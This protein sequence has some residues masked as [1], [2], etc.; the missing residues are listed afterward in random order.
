MP[1]VGRG[2]RVCASA[3]SAGA[4]AVAGGGWFATKYMAAGVALTR[5]GSGVPAG[6]E[7]AVSEPVL[8]PGSV[9][10]ILQL[11]DVDSTVVAIP[12]WV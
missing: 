11:S 10:T 8:R 12:A 4:L 7:S 5:S 3:S 1:P 2:T 6:L 9:L